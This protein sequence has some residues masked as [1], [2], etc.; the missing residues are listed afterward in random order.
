MARI[1]QPGTSGPSRS[2]EFVNPGRS[3][4]L[5]GAG[6][7][8]ALLLLVGATFLYLVGQRSVMSPGDL[9]AHHARIDLKC[10]QCHSPEAGVSSLRCE[11][12]HDPSG[13]DRMLHT[14]HVLLGS[15][16][17]RL[18]DQAPEVACATCHNDHRGQSFDMGRVDDRE[19][20]TCH[21]FRGLRGHPEFAVVRA[22]A[23]AGVGLDFDHDRHVIEAQKARGATCQTCHEQTADR[24][25][26]QPLT[27]DRHCASCHTSGLFEATTGFV[28]AEL[29]LQP[30]EIPAEA[31]AGSNPVISVNARGRRQATGLR[32]RDPWV[33]Y[34]AA[35]LR[36]GIDRGRDA[37][38]RLG[39]RA[40]I[41]YLEQ[42]DRVPAPR[43]VPGPELDTAIA[44]LRDEIAAIDARL[45][46]PQSPGSDDAALGELTAAA[47]AV[48]ASLDAP[49]DEP[50]AAAV[51]PLPDS[52]DPEAGARLERR[53]AELLGLIDAIVQRTPDSSGA[54]RAAE[55][56]AAIEALTA[57]TD[58]ADAD[59][60]ALAVRLNQIGELLGPVRR[61]PDAGVRAELG[62]IDGLRQLAVDRTG[63]GISREEFE[64]RRRELL[65]VLDGIEQRA[66]DSLRVRVEAL[67]QRTMALSAGATGDEETRRRRR[68]R[69]RQLDRLLVERELAASE[70]DQD[71]PPD[72]DAAIDR[73]ELAQALAQARAR[74]AELER[75]P[76]MAAPTTED[77]R[78]DRANALESLLG[79]CLKCHELDT[80][81]ARMAPVRIAEPVMV[82]SVFNHAPHV[83]DAGCETCHSGVL[84][85]KFATDVNVPGVAQCQT[86]HRPSKVRST[87]VTCHTYHPPS[88]VRLAVAAR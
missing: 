54:K 50:A 6:L 57:S 53:K 69:Q 7:V 55:L 39:L 46:A 5:F 38:E 30:S 43:R 37:A 12:C 31:L 44:T 83:T 82:H 13:T 59:P 4:R 1:R 24:R 88:A 66:G 42:L 51:S 77:E 33:L 35:R 41:Q 67:R 36:R 75:A 64:G 87:C 15:G 63:G 18:A 81:R 70:R 80:S 3:N 8:A 71:D 25:A 58:G 14:A 45:M 73:R 17:R 78:L 86:C 61:L 16:D 22:M 60:A 62:G 52:T 11:R 19:C 56:R 26:F 49:L 2:R 29:M 72:Q 65:Q 76:R 84:T 21:Q 20:T 34:N 28:A 79:P 68:Q 23:S 27:F 85:S 74:L 10:A 9:S 47:R 48:A 32:H 40:R